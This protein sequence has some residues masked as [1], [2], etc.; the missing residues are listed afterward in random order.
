MFAVCKPGLLLYALR[1]FCSV[2]FVLLL[3]LP[4]GY[5]IA[6]PEGGTI[7]G[8]SG[9]IDRQ[10]DK[11]TITQHSRDM[12][13]DWDSFN[14]SATEHVHFEQ[15]R[16]T[17]SALNR[18]H[19]ARPS[20]IWGRLTSRGSVWLLNP[21]GVIFS[22]TAKVSTGNLVAAGLW[23][24]SQDFMQGR[25][26]LNNSRGVGDVS[27]AGSLSSSGSIGLA[28]GNVSNSG[29]IRA[30][31]GTVTLASGNHMTVDFSGDGLMRF[32]TDS[33]TAGSVVEHSGSVE[34]TEVSLSAGAAGDVLSGVINTTGVITASS[35]D[36]TGGK[37]SLRAAEINHG[38][39]I[40]ASGT[41]GGEVELTAFKHQSRPSLLSI[42]TAGTGV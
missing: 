37:V 33:A 4:S 30:K 23:M 24:D 3:G 20:E 17:D 35:A 27:N 6:A 12:V 16:S 7:V 40:D 38:G 42:C 32:V 15:Q 5:S 2:T 14:V 1:A 9:D 18:I 11:T 22:R 19:D 13:V 41:T 21:N 28:G 8:G 29:S 10:G 31:A 39:S 36:G 25:Y 34:A 26:V